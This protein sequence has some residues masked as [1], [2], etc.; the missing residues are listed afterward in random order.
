MRKKLYYAIPFVA[1]PV[2]VIAIERFVTPLNIVAMFV[3]YSG[4]ISL[5]LFSAIIG[6]FSPS[7]RKFDYLLTL[8]VPLALF[9]TMFVVG[10]LD[11]TD[12]ETRFHLYKAVKTAFQPVSLQL[13]LAMTITTFLA[14]FKGFRN[15]KNVVLNKLNRRKRTILKRIVLSTIAVV[16]NIV[17]VIWYYIAIKNYIFVFDSLKWAGIIGVSDWKAALSIM[18]RLGDI[19]YLLLTIS[20][21]ALNTVIAIFLSRMAFGKALTKKSKILFCVFLGITVA[22]FILVPYYTYLRALYA[23]FEI[24]LISIF[25]LV[26]FITLVVVFDLIRFTLRKKSQ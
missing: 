6:Y 16:Y 11:K 22:F 21:M 13:Y 19:W 17:T 7:K 20:F 9:C 4:L 1:I 23:V 14:S 10:F 15:L 25:Q 2:I 12:L 24:H 18:L 3:F 8:I 26:Y 5:L